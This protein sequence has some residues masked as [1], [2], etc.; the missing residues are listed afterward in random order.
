MTG[1]HEAREKVE[2]HVLLGAPQLAALGQAFI[3][4][5]NL[6]HKMPGKHDFYQESDAEI[7]AKQLAQEISVN[8]RKGQRTQ[9]GAHPGHPT[10][11]WGGLRDS[12]T[13]RDIHLSARAKPPL[14]SRETMKKAPKS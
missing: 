8:M 3:K 11:P 5:Q 13:R 1:L 10:V 9:A 7:L 4:A 2:L 14:P 6:L 12:G